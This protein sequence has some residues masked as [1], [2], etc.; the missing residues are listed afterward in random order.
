MDDE[1]NKKS[2]VFLRALLMKNEWRLKKMLIMIIFLVIN[3]GL[4]HVLSFILIGSYSSAKKERKEEKKRRR[5][6]GF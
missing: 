3:Q 4:A 5:R 6:R 2:A 1:T